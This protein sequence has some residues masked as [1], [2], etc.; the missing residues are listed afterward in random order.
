MEHRVFGLLR[1]VPA[2]SDRS[3][4][5]GV[6][7]CNQNLFLKKSFDRCLM[8]WQVSRPRMPS[9]VLPLLL[10]FLTTR[11]LSGS[12]HCVRR[13]CGCVQF[14]NHVLRYCPSRPFLIRLAPGLCLLC[15]CCLFSLTALTYP[16][17]SP[18]NRSLLS[19]LSRRRLGI[20]WQSASQ[21]RRWLQELWTDFAPSLPP[22][23]ISWRGAVSMSASP[24]LS[25]FCVCVAVWRS[26]GMFQ[27]P[28]CAPLCTCVSRNSRMF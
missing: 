8:L 11:P 14:R 19:R 5:L 21:G 28:D 23:Q 16:F 25:C 2:R 18:Y 24:V 7:V 22:S 9:L 6:T 12:R 17:P 4:H 26:P 15:V 20:R 27:A 3:L 1:C 10:S 13:P